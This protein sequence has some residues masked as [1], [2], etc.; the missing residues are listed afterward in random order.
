VL[1][2]MLFS[3]GRLCAVERVQRGIYALCIL[4]EWVNEEDLRAL[5]G[6]PAITGSQ[7]SSV[8]SIQLPAGKASPAWWIPTRLD[9]EDLYAD[10]HLAGPRLKSRRLLRTCPDPVEDGGK[11]QSSTKDGNAIV[12][13]VEIAN[14]TVQVNDAATEPV[15]PALAEQTTQEVFEKV[16]YQYLETLYISKARKLPAMLL[17]PC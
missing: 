5:Q 1:I 10:K 13:Q 16:R 7:I 4:G 6:R 2:A 17:V 14:V 15:E 9:R 3:N 11:P 12:P 8:E